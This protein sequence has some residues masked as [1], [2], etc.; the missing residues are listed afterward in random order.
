MASA[1]SQG[2]TTV[3]NELEIRAYGLMRSGNHVIIQWIQNQFA[4]KATCFLNN[5]DHGDHDPFASNRA[6]VLTG[7]SPDITGEALRSL[8]KA[9]L[10]FSYEDRQML[11]ETGQDFLSS[12]F[13]R[14]FE[15][16]RERYL[17]ASDRQFDLL[18]I[19]DPFNCIASRIEL[20]NQRGPMGGVSNLSV[21]ASNWKILARK[22]IDL[23]EHPES[24]HL[25]VSYNRFAADK[26]YRAE[27]SRTLKG[28]FDDSAMD[29]TPTFGGGSS[30]VLEP[31]TV[32]ALAQKWRLLLD[33]GT[34]KRIP[35]YWTRLR[36]PGQQ[37]YFGRWKLY[38]RH[39]PYRALFRDKEV[40]ELSDR[41][42]GEIEGTR[43]FL[44]GL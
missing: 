19:R 10:V 26:A 15:S 23:L 42:F 8:K 5:V 21:I 31:I 13:D 3:T 44:R 34:I 20:I 12:V 16:N 14:D 11:E 1:Q 28:T 22:A 32:R 6:R 24:R 36:G 29:V 27:L 35:E 2:Q 37:D 7:A 18:I 4:G 9:L 39:E 25:V 41:L 33:P 30:F 40:A 38:R 17:G 43:Q